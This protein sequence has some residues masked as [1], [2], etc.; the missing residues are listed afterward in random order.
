MWVAEKFNE[1]VTI[2]RGTIG[3]SR[4][5]SSRNS[6]CGVK[7]RT[8]GGPLGLRVWR[9]AGSGVRVGS[10]KD[11]GRVSGGGGVSIEPAALIGEAKRLVGITAG[12][13]AMLEQLVRFVEVNQVTLAIDKVFP[14][15][16]APAAYEYLDAGRHFGKVAVNVR[17]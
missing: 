3:P 10:G 5:V 16:K 11:I 6:R 4:S 7:R 13:R 1:A 8:D 12:S 9:P 15:D 14:F 2:Q 17:S